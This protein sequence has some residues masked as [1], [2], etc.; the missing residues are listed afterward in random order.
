MP[1]I[2]PLLEKYLGTLPSIYK[3]KK[4]ADP[5]IVPPSGLISK[6]VYKGKDPRATVLLRLTS[7]YD[8]NKYNNE[9]LNSLGEVM[10]IRLLE[11]LRKTES[12]VYSPQCAIYY[13]KDLFQDVP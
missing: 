8:Y 6:T 4:A 1:K 12:G 7:S 3:H 2:K 11:R 5:G 13:D 10:E 9:I